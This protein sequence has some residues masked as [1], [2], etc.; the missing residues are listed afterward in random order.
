M[1]ERFFPDDYRSSIYEIDSKALKDKGIDS[2]IVDIDNT[3]SPWGTTT[4]GEREYGW[5]CCMRKDGFKVCVLSNSSDS[6]ISRYCSGLDVLYVKN[7]HKPARTSFLRAM[8]L[9]NSR[10]ENTCVIGDEVF[11]DILGG[12]S[13][14]LYTILVAPIDKKEFYF[15]RIMRNI[16]KIVLRKYFEKMK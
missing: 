3:L 12:N 15:T 6:R 2:I 11:T 9:L 1:G 14:G 4:P 7:V 13:A 5:L 10:R 16:E 8:K